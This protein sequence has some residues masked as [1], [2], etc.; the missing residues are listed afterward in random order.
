MVRA[1]RAGTGAADDG[2]RDHHGHLGRRNLD[3]RGR[4]HD[5]RTTNDCHPPD[6]PHCDLLLNVVPS[7]DPQ[8]DGPPS[9]GHRFD[10]AQSCDPHFGDHRI[11]ARRS[12][13]RRDDV[14]RRFDHRDARSTVDLL[15][16]DHQT[17]GHFVDRPD[18]RHP[19][20]NRVGRHWPGRRVDLRRNRVMS[21]Q[22]RVKPDPNRAD[23][24]R[25]SNGSRPDALRSDAMNEDGLQP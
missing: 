12:I 15:P 7:D 3:D 5:G 19:G 14:D 18:L 24:V 8:C 16:D 9:C 22:N 13:H 11:A 2:R 23:G 21:N 6:V 25:R 1:L 10:D 17:V 4:T 20:A